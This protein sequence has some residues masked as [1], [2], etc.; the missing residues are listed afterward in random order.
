MLWNGRDSVL[1]PSAALSRG[2]QGSRVISPC[3]LPR[4]FILATETEEERLSVNVV[5]RKATGMLSVNSSCTPA[6]RPRR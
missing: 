5:R 3:R 6:L 4:V 2:A 1:E